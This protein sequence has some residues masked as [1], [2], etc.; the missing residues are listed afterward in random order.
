MLQLSYITENKDAVLA[1]LQK[2]NFKDIGLVSDII[3]MDGTRRK[4]K[5][6]LDTQLA[7]ANRISKEVGKMFAA[8]KK[9]EA[10][11]LKQQSVDLKEQS[12]KTQEDLDKF[13]LAVREKLILLPN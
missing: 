11:A 4:L 13:E 7:E 5:F 1:G 10:D 12:K 9:D 8:G 6:Q 3:E 2:K